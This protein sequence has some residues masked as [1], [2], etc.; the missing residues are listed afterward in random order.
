MS[1]INLT[2]GDW[3][4]DGHEK[5]ETALFD[6]SCTREEFLSAY[7]KGTEVLG[8]DI[9]SFCQDYEDCSVPTYLSAKL[10]QHFPNEWDDAVDDEDDE[11]FFDIGV[12]E[13]MSAYILTVRLGNPDIN[14]GGYGL[15]Y[16]SNKNDNIHKR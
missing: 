1:L 6:V 3:S 5:T 7:K 13:F 16:Y 15:F 12:D 10:Q 9:A 2:V 4:G 11:A 14:I 8:F